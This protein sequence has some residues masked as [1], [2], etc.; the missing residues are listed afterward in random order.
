MHCSSFVL[1]KFDSTN[2][3]QMNE[4]MNATLFASV[5][6]STMILT[7]H[8]TL[9]HPY[10]LFTQQPL[11]QME[12]TIHQDAPRDIRLMRRIERDTIERGRTLSE[13]LSQ[14]AATVRPMH[15]EFV[16]PSKHNAD[17]IV[18][19][20]DED[21]GVSRKRMELAMRVICNHLKM[22]TVI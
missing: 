22:E 19:G 8:F 9:I 21:E 17:L 14:Y 20:H 16:E 18:H 4:W 13:I 6:T 3:N 2:I 1:V 10:Y 7:H 5:V 11:H 15:N 12:R